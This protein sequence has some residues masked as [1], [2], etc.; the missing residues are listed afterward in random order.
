MDIDIEKPFET[1][2]L[3]PDEQ[4]TLEYCM[5]QYIVLGDAPSDF[6]RKIEEVEVSVATSHPSTNVQCNHYVLG[7]FPIK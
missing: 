6:L 7:I 1:Y 4:G 5:C 2:P 3:V